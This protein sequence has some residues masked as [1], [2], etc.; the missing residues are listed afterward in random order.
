[1]YSL[2]NSV[3]TFSRELDFGRASR[4]TTSLSL[5]NMLKINLF[6]FILLCVI[7]AIASEMQ[8][9]TGRMR[10]TE[11]YRELS[12]SHLRFSAINVW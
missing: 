4:P 11:L 3:V 2:P 7:H 8:Q 5:S 12:G 10:F 6:L 9:Q 1:M